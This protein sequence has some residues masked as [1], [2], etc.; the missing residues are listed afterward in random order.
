MKM[1]VIGGNV[2]MG[3]YSLLMLTTIGNQ[4]VKVHGSDFN[5]KKDSSN[6]R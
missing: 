4:S 3:A 5:A 6:M 2:F 1:A